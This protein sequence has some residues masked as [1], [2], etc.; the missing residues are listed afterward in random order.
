MTA[1]IREQQ[2]L[3]RTMPE[4]A[5]LLRDRDAILRR[6]SE[7]PGFTVTVDDHTVNQDVVVI[8]TRTT[9]P[10]DWMPSAVASHLGASTGLSATRVET[11][12]LSDV[13]GDATLTFDLPGVHSSA[14]GSASLRPAGAGC[15]LAQSVD[16]TVEAPLVGPL[17]E[18]ALAGRIA[19]AVL[20]RRGVLPRR[21]STPSGGALI[22]RRLSH[23]RR[24]GRNRGAARCGVPR[25]DW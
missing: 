1:R 10:M 25:W 22:R 15:L 23:R 8:R 3:R 12:R 19:A 6:A 24:A 11:W 21:L 16:V 5:A 7:L 9:I 13:A 14:A 18:Q 17:I 4:V 2:E 20:R